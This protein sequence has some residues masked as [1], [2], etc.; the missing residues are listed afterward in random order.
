MQGGVCLFIQDAQ[1][2]CEQEVTIELGLEAKSLYHYKEP[3][4]ERFLLCEWRFLAKEPNKQVVYRFTNISVDC[5]DTLKAFIEETEFTAPSICGIGKDSETEV[6]PA[7]E[8]KLMLNSDKN[9]HE[10]EKGFTLHMIAAKGDEICPQQP[11]NVTSVKQQIASPRFPNLYAANLQCR[12]VLTAP[13][14]VVLTFEY[15]DVEKHKDCPPSSC[16]DEII[17]YEGLAGENKKLASI[18]GAD[19]FH[20]NLTYESL[21]RTM[22]I[23]LRTDNQGPKRGFVATVQAKKGDPIPIIVPSTTSTT[24]TILTPPV[25]VT[26]EA[27]IYT[28]KTTV[29]SIETFEAWTYGTFELRCFIPTLERGVDISWTKKRVSILT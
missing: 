21:G 12:Y 8:L 14:G 23:E 27:V 10:H 29:S 13:S 22:T 7:G 18:C 26:T 4:Y 9:I 16:C 24:E 19:M 6:T 2:P 1:S 17:V 11:I 3:T 15:I 25:V 28:P 20:P 5:E